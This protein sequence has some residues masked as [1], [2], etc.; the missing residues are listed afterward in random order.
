MKKNNATNRR[1]KKAVRIVKKLSHKMEEDGFASA[2]MMASF[3]IESLIWNVPNYLFG[4]PSL[5]EMTL[6]IIVY[7]R[8]NTRTDATCTTWREESGI[9]CLFHNSQSWTRAQVNRFLCDAMDYV[10]SR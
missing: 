8:E 7:L 9:K 3:L 4:R 1:F 5:Y 6:G 10:G 2:G